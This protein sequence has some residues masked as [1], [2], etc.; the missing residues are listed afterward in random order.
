M[1]DHAFPKLLNKER[2]MKQAANR[3]NTFFHLPCLLYLL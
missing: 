1:A 2:L 3:T